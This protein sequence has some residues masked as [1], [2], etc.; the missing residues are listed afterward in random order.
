MKKFLQLATLL[1]LSSPLFSQDPSID[2]GPDQSVCPP[3]C[4][5]II[6]TYE[7]GGGN[8]NDY[9]VEEIDFAPDP[10]AGDLIDLGDDDLSG[11]LPIGFDFCFYGETYDQMYVHSNGWV[12]F[13]PDDI[14]TFITEPIPSG[15][16]DVPKNC[17]MGPWYDISPG[18]FGGTITYQTLGVAPSR[19]TVISYFEVP[20]FSCSEQLE[21]YQIIL[22]ETTNEIEN[23]IEQKDICFDW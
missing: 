6:A 16:P 23:H 1:T 19:R 14:W 11:V 20:H 5:T 10:Y 9:T 8:T 13:S 4:V 18:F 21:T 17:I 7:G 15:D 12:S 2:A 22:Y 3:E